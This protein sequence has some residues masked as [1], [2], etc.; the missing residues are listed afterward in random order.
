MVP[1]MPSIFNFWGADIFT[2]IKQRCQG[3]DQF[4]NDISKNIVYKSCA[5]TLT[6][7]IQLYL[8]VNMSPN[9]MQILLFLSLKY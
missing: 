7:T 2:R 8:K 9:L 6:T 1:L 4:I 3:Q 5:V